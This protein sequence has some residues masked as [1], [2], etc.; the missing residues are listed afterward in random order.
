MKMFQ[1]SKVV[2]LG[3]GLVFFPLTPDNTLTSPSISLPEDGVL[4][5]SFKLTALTDI[6]GLEEHYAAYVIPE[7]AA[8]TGS[9]TL[10]FVE[11]LD[12]GYTTVAK[13][14]NVDISEFAGQNVQIVFRYYDSTNIFFIAL[15][16]V[17]VESSPSLGVLDVAK[18]QVVVNPDQEVVKIKGFENVNEV[19]V[20]DLTGKKVKQ[21]KDQAVD[22]SALSKGISL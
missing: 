16:D 22:V 11:T 15:D 4:N 18:D 10:V 5:L 6:P 17:K 14:V 3:L 2:L 8:F 1:L 21:V 20:F 19:R 13:T 9:G 12:A 7:G